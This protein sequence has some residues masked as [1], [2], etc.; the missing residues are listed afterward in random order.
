MG[1]GDGL[2]TELP[3][4]I[5]TMATRCYSPSCPSNST[6][7]SPRCPYKL[8]PSS[9]LPAHEAIP[10]VPTPI[11][12]QESWHQDL[13][14]KLLAELSPEA[15]TRQTIITQTIN[16]EVLYQADLAAME[17]FFI[18]GLRQM[19]P[20]LIPYGRLEAFISE[21]FCNASE[22]RQAC[23]LLIESFAIRRLESG[24]AVTMAVGDIFLQAA[25]EFREIYPDYTGNLPKAEAVLKKEFDENVDFRLYC[26]RIVRENDRRYDIRLL[27]TRPSTQLQRYPAVI[28]ALLDA[29]SPHEADYDFLS[30]ALTNIRNL[31]Y[32]SQLK[33]FHASKGR[34]PAGRLKWHN[35]ITQEQRDLMDV[36]EQKRQM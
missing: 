20:P 36:K 18:N 34:G 22:L 21:V 28:E 1:A 12:P 26:E 15:V 3:T 9:F 24:S 19:D 7:Y 11:V 25:V 5:L 6:C 32:L 35:L 33:L 29:T 16:S 4:D 27:I 17:T 2:Y 30:A 23:E 31:S 10:Q 13:D 14:P 8:R